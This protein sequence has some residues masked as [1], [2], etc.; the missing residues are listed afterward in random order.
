M[1]RTKLAQHFHLW[2]LLRNY[3]VEVSKGTKEVCSQIACGW[4]RGP[5]QHRPQN[6]GCLQLKESAWLKV[7]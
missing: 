2:P 1:K 3:K 7:G 5:L 6:S 4:K